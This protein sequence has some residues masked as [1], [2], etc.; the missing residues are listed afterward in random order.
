MV[1]IL[2][3]DPDPDRAGL[4][5]EHIKVHLELDSA[6]FKNVDM[7]KEKIGNAG[8]QIIA[9]VLNHEASPE[10]Y[11]PFPDIPTIVIT[12]GVPTS[13]KEIAFAANVFDYIPDCRGYHLEYLLQLIKRVL[14]ARNSLILV[15]SKEK[16]NRTLMRRLLANKG[17]AVAEAS[18][19]KE[20]LASLKNNNNVC[21]LLVDGDMCEEKNFSLIKTIR[22]DYKKNQL[23]ILALCERT[24]EYQRVMLLRCGANDCIDK[25][26]R[27]EEFQVRVMLNLQLME[28]L[29]ELT[30]FS[31]RDFLTRVYNRKYFFEIGSTLFENYKRD[32]LELTVA[33]I[34]IDDMK[35]INDSFGHLLGDKVI[36]KTAEVLTSNLRSADVIARI[37]GEEFCVLATKVNKQNA[38]QVF[39]RVSDAVKGQAIPTPNGHLKFSVSIGVTTAIKDSFE[40][41]IHAADTN[42]YK[43]KAMGKS[44]VVFG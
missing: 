30:D 37:G 22:N 25:P 15:A 12:N 11:S 31:N 24:K 33:M 27:I 41:M 7:A 19:A 9:L 35:K 42:M 5:E 39:E 43:A 14:F 2:I 36:K 44:R 38:L 29:N 40:E 10:N 16:V 28:V 8:R 21:M 23:S 17:Y 26:V 3:I 1:Q 32:A 6:V 18:G 4:I 20:I 34:D 13:G